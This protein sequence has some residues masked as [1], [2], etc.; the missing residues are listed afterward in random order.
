MKSPSKRDLWCVIAVVAAMM[1]AAPAVQAADQEAKLV[2]GTGTWL[3]GGSLDGNH[4]ALQG[5]TLLLSTATTVHVL[6]GGD[7]R[8]RLRGDGKAADEGFGASLDID[9]DFAVIGARPPYWI[10]K[11]GAAYVFQRT[12]GDWSRVAKLVPSDRVADPFFGNAVAIDGDTIAVGAAGAPNADGVRTGAV[13][14]YTRNGS[15]WSQ[16]TR[17]VPESDELGGFGTS[18]A[19]DGRT[20]IVGSP[21]SDDYR[22]RAHVFVG[23]GAS[24]TRQAT[25]VASERHRLDGFGQKVAI[26][27]DDAAISDYSAPYFYV[28]SRSGSSWGPPSRQSGNVLAMEGGRILVAD[29][30]ARVT[31]SGYGANYIYTRHG[32]DWQRS[33]TLLPTDR[34]RHTNAAGYQGALDGDTA[35]V[36]RY[37][38]DRTGQ[39]YVFDLGARLQLRCATEV[40]GDDADDL[41]VV[42]GRNVT[43]RRFDGSVI[44]RFSLAAPG[45]LFDSE[46][47]A[48]SDGNGAPELALL[49]ERPAAGEVRDLASGAQLSAARFS[50]GLEPVDLEVMPDRNGNGSSELA[51]LGERPD[52]P[53]R[54]VAVELHD[55]L[56]GEFL[57]RTRFLQW[58]LPL[59][60]DVLPALGAGDGP[61]LSLLAADVRLGYNPDRLELR[62][63][64][65][66]DVVREV[67]ING[68][69]AVRQTRIA[70]LNGNGTEEI[71]VLRLY[72]VRPRNPYI[73]QETGNINA[74]IV[75]P[76]SG[77]ELQHLWFDREYPPERMVRLHDVDGNG[78]DEVVVFGQ[79][80]G[81]AGNNQK[82]KILDS[83]TGGMAGAGVVY[84]DKQWAAKDLA[85]CPDANGNGAEELAML[86]RRVGS[87]ALMVIV[88]DA[89]TGEQLAAVPF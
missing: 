25:L 41:V 69:G 87:N 49:T 56:T 42:H 39:V 8:A 9:G 61:V 47:M 48:D 74:V 78:A 3:V 40:D 36:I 29:G 80:L 14:V 43:V 22:G 23:E 12:A 66:G 67:F 52:L 26:D 89:A 76:E 44:N 15:R 88:K 86:G 79:R 32:E 27:A 64:A 37:T 30:R 51:A 10:A 33:D 13:Y 18:V 11:P 7:D 1:G 57:G 63:P 60:L 82:A 59:D 24:W 34:G 77:N 28:F 17:L 55:G 71:A 50:S 53:V 20:M 31:S 4:A 84:F 19:L 68:G 81:V 58:L 6:V 5:D 54:R 72:P 85:V 16:Q 2:P 38:Q 70:D 83:R 21:N 62:D 75:D 46:L 65:T 35:V 45:R 73:S